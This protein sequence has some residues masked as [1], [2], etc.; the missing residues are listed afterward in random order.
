MK[1]WNLK[2]SLQDVRFNSILLHLEMKKKEG[3][4]RISITKVG[5]GELDFLAY[6]NVFKTLRFIKFAGGIGRNMSED[7][8]P[9]YDRLEE[10]LR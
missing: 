7:G 6:F 3:R 10:V 9:V 1:L 2:K 8:R 5:I 4:P